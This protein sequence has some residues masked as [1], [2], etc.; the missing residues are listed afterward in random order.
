MDIVAFLKYK[1]SGDRE[2]RNI[3]A[4]VRKTFKLL[5]RLPKGSLFY[6][7]RRI[8]FT[9]TGRTINSW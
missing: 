7:L 4:G 5:P 3:V 9:A 1:S 6:V 8:L 2:K